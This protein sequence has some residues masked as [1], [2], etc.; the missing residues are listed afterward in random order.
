MIGKE[1]AEAFISVL[2]RSDLPVIVL[3][4]VVPII[5]KTV[6]FGSDAILQD[7]KQQRACTT[8]LVIVLF[9]TIDEWLTRFVSQ[10]IYQFKMLRR[11]V[12]STCLLTLAVLGTATRV[13]ERKSLIIDTDLFS[14]VE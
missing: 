9:H 13:P 14:D 4:S 6:T 1:T 7:N 12:T 8:S 10:Q 11:L 3:D 5:A 2:P